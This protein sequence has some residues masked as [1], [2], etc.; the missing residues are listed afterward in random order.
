[1]P[2]PKLSRVPVK[3]EAAG[4]T[5]IGGR[6]HNEDAIQLRPDLNLYMIADGAGG[7]NAGNVASSLALTTIAH[8]FEQT[9]QGADKLPQYDGLGLPT[10]A[11]RLS[12]AVQEANTE[13]LEISKTSD[14]H[15]GMGTTIV[16]T[17]FDPPNR[18][19]HVA[20]VGDSRCYRF[21]DN[22][23]EQLTFDHSLINDVLELKPNIDDARVKKL[24]Q[25]V[26]TR[27]L[28]M[29]DSLRVSIRSHGLSHGDRYML[30]SDGLSDVVGDHQIAEALALD[31][32][33][34]EQVQLMMNMALDA[35]ADD[36]VAI[37]V[38]DVALP[39]GSSSGATRPIKKVHKRASRDKMRRE[40]AP[41]IV[42]Y[43]QIPTPGDRETSP[44][45]H[46]VPPAGT[47][48]EVVD[49]VHNVMAK[50]G[51]PL[52]RVG[53]KPPPPPSDDGRYAI[54][55]MS[56]M[57]G[58][59]SPPSKP[60][61][62]SDIPARRSDAPE[63]KKQKRSLSAP[64]IHKPH[65]DSEAQETDKPPSSTP[66]KRPA[67]ELG[68][69]PPDST[70]PGHAG[71]TQA[72]PSSGA[73]DSGIPSTKLGPPHGRVDAGTERSPRP[74]ERADGTV[75]GPPS[76]PPVRISHT[77]PGGTQRPGA[78]PPRALGPRNT[79]MGTPPPPLKPGAPVPPM[80]EPFDTSEFTGDDSI[81]CHACGSII[82]RRAEI[83][84]YCGATT[85]FVTKR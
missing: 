5:H 10:A 79:L 42:L 34:D 84:M 56:R 55:D 85:G 75:P 17:L 19:L 81:P 58:D 32:D 51:A 47:S 50:D 15:K 26:I 11:R 37:V 67:D 3:I 45:I 29:S 49:A 83:C 65:V 63:G 82:S 24:P 69:M 20:Y 31:V 12:A 40:N 33:C 2:D 36:N 27:A 78:P 64:R 25:N 43:D 14:K 77:Q 71:A 28:G 46:V 38:I 9:A 8:F 23:L 61:L 66:T 7:Q 53:S 6:T 72:S 54:V 76:V 60:S 22:R 52:P 4:D 1:M 39:T 35:G 13:I 16:A 48:D 74:D 18:A 59:D 41:E 73:R 44:T 68:A 30:C 57:D 70:P 21:R 62:L 80:R